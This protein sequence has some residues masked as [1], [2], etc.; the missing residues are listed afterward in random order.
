MSKIPQSERLYDL[1]KLRHM[2]GDDN[3][4]VVRMVK[5]FLEQTPESLAQIDQNFKAGNLAQ[6]RTISHKMKPSI[7]FMG[8]ESLKNEIRQIEALADEGD[9]NNALPPL[10]KQLNAIALQVCEQLKLEL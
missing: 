4:F 7:D 1:S 3:A 5:M 8:I 2:A 9:P 10:L 6:V